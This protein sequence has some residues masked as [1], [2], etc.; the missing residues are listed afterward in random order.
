MSQSCL[1]DCTTRSSLNDGNCCYDETPLA[2]AKMEQLRSEIQ[3][4]S[5]K[6]RSLSTQMKHADSE[7]KKLEDS[8]RRDILEKTKKR[9]SFCL[10]SKEV[11]SF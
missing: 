10:D 3:S 11:N 4:Q 8:L 7:Q 2:Y 9:V 5:S 6:I 1:Q